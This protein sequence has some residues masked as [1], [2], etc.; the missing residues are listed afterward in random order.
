MDVNSVQV[1]EGEER[2][3]G[4]AR[5]TAELCHDFG[6]SEI[7]S[8]KVGCVLE[9]IFILKRSSSYLVFIGFA[10]QFFVNLR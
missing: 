10:L 8:I 9:D 6:V 3:E 1:V 5:V 2:A 4:A 7:Y